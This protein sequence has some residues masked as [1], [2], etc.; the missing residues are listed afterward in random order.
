MPGRRPWQ[1]IL[2]PLDQLCRAS[3]LL[4]PSGCH[5]FPLLSHLKAA[6]ILSYLAAVSLWHVAED[7]AGMFISPFC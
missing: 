5:L 1:S 7:D 3:V 2:P 6:F 4:L